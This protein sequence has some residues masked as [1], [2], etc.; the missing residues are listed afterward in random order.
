MSYS[1]KPKLSIYNCYQYTQGR[2]CLML[3]SP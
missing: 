1:L 2:A 3:S